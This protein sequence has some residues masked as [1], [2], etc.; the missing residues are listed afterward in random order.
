[1][2]A[3]KVLQMPWTL[4]AR[5]I[6]AINRGDAVI[7][8]A[9]EDMKNCGVPQGAIVCILHGHDHQETARMVEGGP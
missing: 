8:A 5:T 4:S 7:A 6:R 3:R 9:I 2:T 1:M